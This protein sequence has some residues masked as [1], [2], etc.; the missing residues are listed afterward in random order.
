MGPPWVRWNE[1]YIPCVNNNRDNDYCQEVVL[2]TIL[3]RPM[4]S[5]AG[6]TPEAPARFE[7]GASAPRDAY[8]LIRHIGG[9]LLKELEGSRTSTIG[10]ARPRSDHT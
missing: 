7:A 3:A 6:G 9:T 10:P 1:W 8:L 2:T 4:P 5:R